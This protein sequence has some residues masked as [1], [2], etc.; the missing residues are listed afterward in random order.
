MICSSVV[1]YQSW[2]EIM[3]VMMP[4]VSVCD[5]LSLYAGHAVL[6]KPSRRDMWGEQPVR[7][8]SVWKTLKRL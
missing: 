2:E 5:W 1:M 7:N 6:H 3:L 8:H 4:A